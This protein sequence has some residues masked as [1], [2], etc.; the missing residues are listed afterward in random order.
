VDVKTCC[1]SKRT[2]EVAEAAAALFKNLSNNY[3]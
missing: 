3:L 1:T 2:S